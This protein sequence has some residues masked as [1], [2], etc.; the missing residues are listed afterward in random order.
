[1]KYYE[2]RSKKRAG[3]TL[4]LLLACSL[5]AVGMLTW[6]AVSRMVRPKNDNNSSVSDP[7]NGMSY[8]ETDSSYNED[9]TMSEI[10]S[11]IVANPVTDIPYSSEEQTS[12]AEPEE[13]KQAPIM[14]IDGKLLKE[15]STTALQFSATYN[16]LRLHNGIDIEA[17]AGSTVK[18]AADGTVTSTEESATLGKTVTID[19][20]NG[21]I[22]KYCGLDNVQ[23]SEGKKVKMGDP[24][25]VVG[26]IPCECADKSH[27]H[28]EATKKGESISPMDVIGQLPE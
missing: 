5:I 11:S 27:L 25:A 15:H 3:G 2:S 17:A 28:L 18:A 19:H 7:S 14:P 8:P 24:I 4:Y 16:D 10:T 1:M 22:M 23:V 9:T 12:A 6:F 13:P 20:G 21:I 26:S